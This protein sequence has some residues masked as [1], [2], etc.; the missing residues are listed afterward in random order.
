MEMI[1]GTR[2]EDVIGKH[3]LEV[4][5]ILKEMGIYADLEQALLGETR[6]SPDLPYHPKGSTNT[7][8]TR[9]QATPL[10]GHDGKITGVLAII[11]DITELKGTE[12]ALRE[13]ERKLSEALRLSQDR[14]VQLEEQIQSRASFVSMV[15]KSAPLQEVYRLLRLAAESDVTVLLTGESGTGKE[16]AAAAVHSLSHR[17][18]HPFVGVNCSAIPESL[19]E[20][21]LFGHVKGAFTGATRDKVGLFQA[22]EG[23]TLFLDEVG[24][25]SPVLQVKVLRALQE[26]EIRRVGEDQV[27]KIN[28]RLV[29]ATNRNMAELVDT[30]VLRED[31]YYR[32]RV[33]EIRLPPLRERRED[34]S[35]IVNHFIG[36][37]SR[38]TGKRIRDIA[39]EAL[40]HL[41]DYPWPGNVRELKNALEHAFV[42]AQ[43]D[44]LKADDLPLEIRAAAPAGGPAPSISGDPQERA[45]IIEALEKASGKKGEAARRLGISRVTLWH[46]MR[47]LGIDSPARSQSR[48]SNLTRRT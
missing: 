46:R 12:E 34:I 24:D 43:G 21:E 32:I 25:M 11:H 20:S 28:V 14:V 31:F 41:M 22:A 4:F 10:R 19:L 39:P 35:L 44:L 8:W 38:E 13:S 5:P 36:T 45:R 23:G 17:R 1:T 37:L 2:A 16:L 3:H 7:R 15:G 42:T 40:K 27:I 9:T 33:F 48:K 30:G 29:T 26:R 47:I 18:T 6:T